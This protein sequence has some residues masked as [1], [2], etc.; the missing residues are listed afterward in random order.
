MNSR[1]S[2]W[3][4]KKKLEQ[5]E[6]HWYLRPEEQVVLEI[7]CSTPTERSLFFICFYF[8]EQTRPCERTRVGFYSWISL[9]LWFVKRTRLGLLWS[10]LIPVWSHSCVLLFIIASPSLEGTGN[11][12]SQAC[13]KSGS[14][15]C[16][17]NFKR[18]HISLQMMNRGS[19]LKII[20]S[21]VSGAGRQTA[22][23]DWLLHYSSLNQSEEYKWRDR[24]PFWTSDNEIEADALVFPGDGNSNKYPSQRWAQ[25]HKP[26]R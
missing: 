13:N 26:H 18:A 16:I 8:Q 15:I 10:F 7:C 24:A 5:F 9:R 23:P 6:S 4:P 20:S 21:L 25:R 11:K 12:Y 14:S 3:W 2:L 19:L 17:I 1:G 22:L